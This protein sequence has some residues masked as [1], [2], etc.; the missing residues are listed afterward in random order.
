MKKYVSGEDSISI[1]RFM[2]L[3]G[4]Y[5]EH[6]KKF[7]M[8][9]GI[10]QKKLES[11]HLIFPD[12]IILPKRVSFASYNVE[13]V[14]EG[15]IIQVIDE[16]N[17]VIA[18]QNPIIFNENYLLTNLVGIAKREDLEKI[19]RDN[20]REE[21]YVDFFGEIMP[22]EEDEELEILYNSSFTEKLNRSNSFSEGGGRSLKKIKHY[23]GGKR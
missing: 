22:I 23:C 4:Y 20:L 12:E 8:T 21:G 17:K 18:Y 10:M 16:C 14:L 15:K 3:C 1:Y 5:C 19:R 9:H 11:R 13:D 6:K 7:R 2:E